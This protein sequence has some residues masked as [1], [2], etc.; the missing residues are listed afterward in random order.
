MKSAFA[1]WKG[2]SSKSGD[3]EMF[4][5]A[6][7]QHEAK[8]EMLDAMQAVGTEVKDKA[9]PNVVTVTNPE[10]DRKVQEKLITAR[11]GL[12]LKAPFF[13]NLATRLVLK[14]ADEWLSTAATDGRY[15]Y[16]NSE[17][18]NKL[19]VKQTE[20]LFGHET[21][22]NVY[23]HMG[24]RDSR[25]PQLFNIACD[26]AVNADLLDQRIGEK[27]TV[28]PIL[29]DTKYKG[30]SAE[31]IYEKL[32]ENAEKIDINQ[33]IKQ[34][35]DEHL[36]GEGDDG[37]GKGNGQ[38]GA[39]GRPVLS[40]EEKKAIRDEIK[41]AV[42]G[43]AQ[44]CGAGNLPAGVKRMLADMTEPK[45]NWRELLQQQIESTI[46]ADY[47]WMKP[48]R[49]SWHL[50]AIL[51]GQNVADMIDIAISVDLSGSISD[52]Q[53]KEFFSEIHG[54]MQMYEAFKIQVWT[55]D[56]QVYNPATFTQDNADELLEYIPQ[57]GGGTTFEANWEFMKENDIVPKKFIMF[58]DGYPC[59]GWGDADYC[60]TVF[61]IHGNNTIEPPFGVWAYYDE[62]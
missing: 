32:Y 20:F 19:N 44:S 41:E 37:D 10:T 1:G 24:R 16:Y 55:F 12:L 50:D 31:E 62:A 27:I 3:H 4:S 40:E 26:Y 8:S 51:P 49:R 34:L 39:S 30:M 23:D 15:F 58:T 57:G 61:V 29:F 28:V 56:T 7:K 11:I 43:A 53:C 5:Y 36:D 6:L 38:G 45:M 9:K 13:G 2:F 46:K 54:I 33:L 59:G 35:L 22:H 52:K 48:S 47:T 25:D 14:N 42:L 21:L 18:V 60:D 17:F